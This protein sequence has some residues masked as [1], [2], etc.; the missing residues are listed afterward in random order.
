VAGSCEQD[1]KYWGESLSAK[2]LLAF[3]EGVTA[4]LCLTC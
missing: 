1:G 4:E 2:R 3:A